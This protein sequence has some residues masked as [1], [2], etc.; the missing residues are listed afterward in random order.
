MNELD[1]FLRNENFDLDVDED[2]L[3]DQSVSDVRVNTAPEYSSLERESLADS[4]LSHDFLAPNIVRFTSNYH[5]SKRKR[6]RLFSGLLTVALSVTGLVHFSKA[7][8]SLSSEGPLDIEAQMKASEGIVNITTNATKI[9][10]IDEH[11]RA[12]P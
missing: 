12:K 2:D 3:D 6:Q 10:I 11:N 7:V 5:I 4:I 9:N 8:L 1:A